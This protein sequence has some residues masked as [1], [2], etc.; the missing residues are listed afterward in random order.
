MDAID[1]YCE[2]C[3]PGLLAEPINAVTNVSFIVAAWSAHRIARRLNGLTPGLWVLICLAVA[4]AAGSGLFHTFATG[5]SRVL[6]I[7]PILL[8]QLTFLWLYVRRVM[9]VR[10]ELAAAAVVLYVVVALV[11]RQF[12]AFLNGA[13]I[14]APALILLLFV[15]LYHLRHA[16]KHRLVLLIAAGVFVLSLLFR[17]ID[18][19]ICPYFPIGTHFLWH[20]FNGLVIFLS[21]FSLVHDQLADPSALVESKEAGDRQGDG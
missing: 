7:V 18:Q 8:F 19:A 1:L 2:R 4:I 11:A 17:T 5:W 10:W 14:Y 16:A 9:N 15:G 20:V 13:P 21:M 12:K 6:D 3:G